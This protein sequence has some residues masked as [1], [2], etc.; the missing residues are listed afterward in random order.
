MSICPLCE[1][2]IDAAQGLRAAA[3]VRTVDASQLLADA[4]KEIERMRAPAPSPPSK[5][6]A[7]RRK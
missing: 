2:E 4:I 1:S 6:R 7:R 5:R 3:K